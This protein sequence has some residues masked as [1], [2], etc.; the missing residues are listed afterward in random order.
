MRGKSFFLE[1]IH[2]RT[3]IF[4]YALMTIGQFYGYCGIHFIECSSAIAGHVSG[5]GKDDR[6]PWHVPK[7]LSYTYPISLPIAGGSYL[8]GDV[9]FQFCAF[10][11]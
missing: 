6:F 8:D 7:N 4:I 3:A 9:L 11:N 1:G 5:D 2:S 10:D